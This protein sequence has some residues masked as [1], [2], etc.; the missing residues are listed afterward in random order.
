[1]EWHERGPDRLGYTERDFKVCDFRGALNPVANLRLDSLLPLMP[2]RTNRRRALGYPKRSL[3]L[4]KLDIGLPQF[5][6]CPV[7][8]VTPKQI[9]AFAQ[10]GP[11]TPPVHL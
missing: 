8:Y 10:G 9:A 2:Y 4:G 3:G 7:R 5:F 1:M 6:C 11:L